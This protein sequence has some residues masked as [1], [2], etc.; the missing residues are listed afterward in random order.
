MFTEDFIFISTTLISLIVVTILWGMSVYLFAVAILGYKVKGKSILLFS[1]FSIIPQL[2]SNAVLVYM[3][4]SDTLETHFNINIWD[5]V[6]L[7]A[8]FFLLSFMLSRSYQDNLLKIITT[9][10]LAQF[11]CHSIYYMYN[12][13]FI[14]LF[15]EP[16]EDSLVGLIILVQL[17]PYLL[18]LLPFWGASQV[19]SLPRPI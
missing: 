13:I 12:E 17:M 8:S 18:L 11:V 15:L 6:F 9:A 1:L 4:Y 7:H 16:L 14:L 2:I 5:A 3:V 19:N 10:A